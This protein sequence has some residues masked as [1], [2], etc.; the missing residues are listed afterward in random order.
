MNIQ[1]IKLYFEQLPTIEQENLMSELSSVNSAKEFQLLKV[2][3]YQLNEKQGVCPHCGYEKYVKAGKD[4]AVQRYK[5]KKCHRRFTSYSGTWMAHIHKKEK[6]TDYL[7]LMKQGL[8][9]EKIRKLLKINK[10]TAFDWR[11]KI[12]IS[13]KD[14]YEEEFTGITESDETFF[15]QSEKGSLNLKR[16]S[17]KRGK[18]VKSKG[19]SNEQI[20]VIVS[21]DRKGELSLVV[22]APGR[23]SKEDIQAAIGKKINKLTVLCSDGHVSYKSFALNNKLE[24]H[25]LRANIKEFV[26][27]NYH[28]QHVNSLHSRLKKWINEDLF[29]VATK[30]LQNY[31]N[32]YRYKEKYKSVNYLKEVV[33]ATCVNINARQDYIYAVNNYY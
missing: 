2:R 30:Y 32:W 19:I 15:L 21:A 26:K 1:E 10:K 11:H 27:G 6:L 4:K 28:I 33:K 18:Q 5:C 3:E 29:G 25:V 13:I 12:L 24:H 8:S 9:L 17:R 16:K 20:P 22:S 23:I 7:K 14:T 31:M